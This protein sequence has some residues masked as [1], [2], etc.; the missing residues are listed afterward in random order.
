L[1]SA[2]RDAIGQLPTHEDDDVA[3][4]PCRRSLD[5]VTLPFTLP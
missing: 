1:R 5:G 3:T 2:L 4:C